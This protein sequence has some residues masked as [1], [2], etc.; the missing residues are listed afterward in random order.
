MS[1]SYDP[2]APVP[3]FPAGLRYFPFCSG[4]YSRLDGLPTVEKRGFGHFDDQLVTFL[5]K[6]DCAAGDNAATV[7]TA[8]WLILGYVTFN[9]EIVQYN[10]QDPEV[11][12]YRTELV[13][14]TPRYLSTD[15]TTHMPRLTRHAMRKHEANCEP[16]YQT[17]HALVKRLAEHRLSK[18]RTRV[19]TGDNSDAML[20]FSETEF[21]WA[22]YEHRREWPQNFEVSFSLLLPALLQRSS[23]IGCFVW[24]WCCVYS[25]SIHAQSQ[26]TFTVTAYLHSHS[27]PYV[28]T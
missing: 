25:H 17:L 14:G 5:I 16:I 7:A 20:I 19:C 28:R 8:D 13:P 23:F 6:L 9:A 26:H 4:D 22:E 3:D 27:I 1:M 2:A 24:I 21:R 11:L 15:Y 12:A 18:T 10:P